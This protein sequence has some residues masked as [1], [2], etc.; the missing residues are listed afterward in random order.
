M[1]IDL[2]TLPTDATLAGLE[3]IIRQKET[4]GFELVTLAR[5]MVSG[6]RSNTASFRILAQTGNQPPITLEEISGALALPQQEAQLNTGSNAAKQLIS[7]AAVLLQDSE[8][9]VAAWR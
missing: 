1:A 3:K 7:Y 4:L 2:D 8:T 5:G 9:N 6:Q